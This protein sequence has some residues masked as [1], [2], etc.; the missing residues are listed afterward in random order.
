MV[1]TPVSDNNAQ[2]QS[3]LAGRRR[4]PTR[5]SAMGSALR[6][7]PFRMVSGK[8]FD[9]RG[10]KVVIEDGPFERCDITE[11]KP[12]ITLTL[13]L[14]IVDAETG[15]G[16]IPGASV[17]IWH[18]DADGAYSDYAG[19]INRESLMTTYLRG[20]QT[21][22]RAGRVTF[23]T[24]Y[25]G[26]RGWRA[27]HIYVRIADGAGRKTTVQLGFPDAT[28]ATVYSDAER[29][30]RGQNPTQNAADPVFGRNGHSANARDLEFQIAPLAGDNATGY[31]AMLEIPVKRFRLVSMP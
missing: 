19:R 3:D 12:G 27:T 17:E 31:A 28:N 23:T 13:I 21:T 20:A 2:S 22:D 5:L 25:P 9:L 6:R 29:Y 4:T 18:C 26:W 24:I 16:P 14:A 30:V 10:P 11:G 1:M 15:F 8:T 7:E